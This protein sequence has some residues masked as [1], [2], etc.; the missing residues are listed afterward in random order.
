MAIAIASSTPAMAMTDAKLGVNPSGTYTAQD[1]VGHYCFD[2]YSQV[3]VDGGQYLGQSFGAVLKIEADD[4]NIITLKNFY[5]ID[6]LDIEAEFNAD[7]MTFTIPNNSYLGSLRVSGDVFTGYL[8]L[9]HQTDTKNVIY[10]GDI[11]FHIDPEKR[12]ITYATTPEMTEQNVTLMIVNEDRTVYLDIMR[13]ITLYYANARSYYRMNNIP[14]ISSPVCYL[15]K[16]DNTITAYNFNAEGWYDRCPVNFIYDPDKETL[17]CKDQYYIYEPEVEEF[18]YMISEEGNLNNELTGN[19]KSYLNGYI[20]EFPLWGAYNQ[21]YNPVMIF[22]DYRLHIYGDLFGPAAETPVI[23]TETDNEENKAMVTI[24]ANEGATIYYTL[25][26]SI[27]TRKSEIYS[28]PIEVTETTIVR[29][30]AVENDLKPSFMAEETVT[31]D[32]AVRSI[33]AEQN[34]TVCGNDI[35][36]PADATVFNAAGYKVEPRGLAAGIYIVRLADGTICKIMVK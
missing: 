8:C 6:A 18:N 11:V 32:N 20:V 10:D 14:V 24:S 31:F 27:P 29:A 7:D 36:A 17:Y 12:C 5:N 28:N 4:S 33:G 21:T 19:I 35:I 2:Y 13:D 22:Y 23:S 16:N 25:D 15:Q 30:F 9:V 1:L 26:G 3:E 34:I